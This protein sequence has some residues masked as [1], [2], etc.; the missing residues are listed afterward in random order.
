[1]DESIRLL[2]LICDFGI[3]IKRVEGRAKGRRSS[4]IRNNLPLRSPLPQKLARREETSLS[5]RGK[6]G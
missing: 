4:P 3:I 6:Q 1:M 5:S 2:S